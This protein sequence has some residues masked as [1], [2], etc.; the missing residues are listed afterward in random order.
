MAVR[1]LGR[2]YLLY[3]VLGGQL[4]PTI[5]GPKRL[6]FGLLFLGEER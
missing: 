6:G 4:F 5:L 3:K 1:I 2:A